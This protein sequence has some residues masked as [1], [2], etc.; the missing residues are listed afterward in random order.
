MQD[1]EDEKSG[2]AVLPGGCAK[3]NERHLSVVQRKCV[4]QRHEVA[5]LSYL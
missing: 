4:R 5:L 1:S 2:V 3:T